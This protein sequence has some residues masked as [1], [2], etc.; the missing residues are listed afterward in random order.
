V[1]RRRGKVT[2][3]WFRARD[4]VTAVVIV[5]AIDPADAAFPRACRERMAAMETRSSYDV[6]LLLVQHVRVL[7]VR[8]AATG[9]TGKRM[10]YVRPMEHM[11]LEGHGGG[12]G[13]RLLRDRSCTRRRLG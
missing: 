8:T 5:S 3:V 10:G 7:R 4:V 11:R 12:R 2:F 9:I 1:H 13:R 6:V